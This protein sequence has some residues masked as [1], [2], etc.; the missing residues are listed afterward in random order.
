MAKHGKKH[1]AVSEKL[2][3]RVYEFEDAI[4]FLKENQVATFDE[5]AELAIRLRY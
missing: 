5:T 1:S 2:E 3:Q 4:A